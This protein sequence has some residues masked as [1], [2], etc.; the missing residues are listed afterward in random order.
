M[1]VRELSAPIEDEL[2][3]CGVVAAASKETLALVSSRERRLMPNWVSFPEVISSRIRNE[4][5]TKKGGYLVGDGMSHVIT[6]EGRVEEWE[7]MN[8]R[9]VY[10]DPVDVFKGEKK[11]KKTASRGKQLSRF[12]SLPSPG[13]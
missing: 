6:L 3:D 7:L 9:C 12:M 4:H 8:G 5:R 1:G 13:R 2:L 11:G 10:T